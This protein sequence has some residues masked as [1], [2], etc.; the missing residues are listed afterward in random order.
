MFPDMR[1]I[2]IDKLE[3]LGAE[4]PGP[5]RVGS[6][7]LLRTTW[8]G[9]PFTSLEDAQELFDRY[10]E[11]H[12]A[13]AGSPKPLEI[14]RVNSGYGVLVEWVEGVGLGAHILQL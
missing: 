10:H 7:Q 4:R 5:W 11:A 8:S 6:D 1:F 12:V 3:S 13:G 9:Q 2:D 14:V